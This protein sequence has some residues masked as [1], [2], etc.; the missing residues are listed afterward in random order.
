MGPFATGSLI[1][2]SVDCTCEYAALMDMAND[3]DRE[4]QFMALLRLH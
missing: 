4:E 1:E 3:M 2:K